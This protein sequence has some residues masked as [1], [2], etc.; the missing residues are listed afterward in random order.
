MI[1]IRRATI[2][3]A[4]GLAILPGGAIAQSVD[5]AGIAAASDSAQD[6]NV[7]ADNMEVLESEKKAIFSGKVHGERAGTKFWGD[8]MVV[9]YADAVRA[10]GSKKT[11]VTTV[12]VD[13]NVTIKTATQTITGEHARLDLRTDTL[14]VTGDVKVVQGRTVIN[15]TTLKVDL[16]AKTSAMTGGRVKGSFVPGGA[17]Q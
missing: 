15:G 5:S 6:V 12:D 8:R 11:E 2:A 13:G 3:L 4:I 10:D 7:E 9:N 17:G 16:K 14:T 1:T